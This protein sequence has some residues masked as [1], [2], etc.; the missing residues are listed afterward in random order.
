MRYV[1]IV[2][3]GTGNTGWGLRLLTGF[4]LFSIL[5]AAAFILF[6]HDLKRLLAYHSV[7]HIGIITL[8]V[9]LG[10]LGTFAA[11]FHTLNHS[12][13]KTLAFFAAGRLGQMFGTHDMRKLA[14]TMRAAPVWGMGLFGSLLALIGV[15]PFALFMSELQ[16]LK[17]AMDKGA[18]L[19]L[20]FFLLGAG[21]VFVG[22]LGHAIPLAWGKTASA[23]RPTR[24]GTLE[25][26]LVVLPLVL[27]LVLGMWMP[28]PLQTAL[29][30]AADV[31]R[32]AGPALAGSPGG[33]MR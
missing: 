20:V 19:A 32:H 23:V 33:V 21:V 28:G 27:L 4:G 30:A 10:G 13:C 29:N 1:P 7:E 17:A 31:I 26:L 6:Q 5:V 18:I 9:G 25:T 14:G 22:A 16:I 15:A 8:G 12:L 3:A 24:A 11:L 2:E